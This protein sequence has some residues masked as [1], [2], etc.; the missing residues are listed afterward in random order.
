VI[1]KVYKGYILKKGMKKEI[2]PKTKKKNFK[3]IYIIMPLIFIIVGSA[4][5]YENYFPTEV[6]TE[7]NKEMCN[8]IKVTP[9]WVNETQI[10]SIGYNN[11]GNADPKEIVDTLIKSKIYLVYHS[12]CGACKAQIEYFGS[13]WE[14]YYASGYAIDC[15]Y[16]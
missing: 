11:F 4:I 14:R 6:N 5:Y 7:I 9:S 13:E 12:S 8:N 10:L 16:S 2:K 1:R 3:M 15:K